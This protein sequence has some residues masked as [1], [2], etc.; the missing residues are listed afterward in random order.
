[1]LS[2]NKI[3]SLYPSFG[4]IAS[5]TLDELMTIQRNN[6]A[7]TVGRDKAE[8]W[9]TLHADIWCE[10]NPKGGKEFLGADAHIGQE[11]TIWRIR[12]IDGLKQ[13]DRLI[14]DEEIHEVI[15]ITPVGRKDAL[16]I[17]TDKFDNTEE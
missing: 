1:M 2:G 11:S 13:A 15:S 3:T 4:N 5:G 7:R 17:L 10:R 8:N 12:H 9:E 16:L 14:V 6:G